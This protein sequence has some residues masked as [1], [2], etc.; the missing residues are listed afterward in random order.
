LVS[1]LTLP[2]DHD[3]A[4][5]PDRPLPMVLLIHDGP[6]SRDNWGFGEG[7]RLVGELALLHRSLRW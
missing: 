4:G 2:R 1:Y 3:S 5:T 7:V 6:W